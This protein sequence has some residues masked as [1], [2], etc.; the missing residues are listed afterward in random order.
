MSSLWT[1]G[2]LLGVPVIK[3]KFTYI[4]TQVSGISNIPSDRNDDKHGAQN[5]FIQQM[6]SNVIHHTTISDR[7][8][9]TIEE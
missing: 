8:F 7:F 5:D 3:R 1:K 2:R 9:Y 4:L 6:S